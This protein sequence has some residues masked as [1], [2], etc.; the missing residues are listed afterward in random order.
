[1]PEP[2]KTL[3]THLTEVMR[4]VRDGLVDRLWRSREA[5]C[6]ALAELLSGRTFSEVHP[7]PEPQPETKPETKPEPLR[8]PNASPNP[9]P[10]PS[11]NL[12]PDALSPRCAVAIARSACLRSCL[13]GDVHARPKAMRAPPQSTP[14]A[15]RSATRWAR[16]SR[17]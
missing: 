2:K 8:E 13:P 14:P 6:A 12:S 5:S 11:P 17:S 16:C 7:E 9:S 4:H 10:S 15:R 1:M 3:A